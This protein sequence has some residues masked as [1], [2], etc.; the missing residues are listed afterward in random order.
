[1]IATWRDVWFEEGSAQSARV[2][3]G[4][5]ELIT[6]ATERTVAYAIHTNDSAT[7]ERYSRFLGPVTKRLLAKTTNTA[8]KA[9]LLEFRSRSVDS[10]LYLD[11]GSRC[12]RE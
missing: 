7:L 5:M 8:D 2:F 9:R 12:K 10:A 4:R 11:S 1:M 6:A 3:A